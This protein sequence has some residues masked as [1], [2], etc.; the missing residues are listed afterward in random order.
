MR[1]HKWMTTILIFMLIASVIYIYGLNTSRYQVKKGI[2]YL[3]RPIA[4]EVLLITSAGQSTDTYIIK[5]VA[6]KLMI[7]NYF[8]PQATD[9][10]LE[11]IKTVAVVIGYSEIGEK[12]HDQQIDGEAERI[13]QLLKN[14][15]DSSM[16]VIAI[17]IGG[18]ERRSK[19]TDLL[20]ETVLN[21]SDYVIT[22]EAGDYDGLI[23][24]FANELGIPASFVKDVTEIKEPFVSAFR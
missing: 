21:Y 13:D 17:Y 1:R 3:P 12:L 8:M 16:T 22:D 7:N 23:S 20:I 24:N 5:D 10:D 19:E 11:E 4:E 15:N 14:A 9:L 18:K 6:N 2:P